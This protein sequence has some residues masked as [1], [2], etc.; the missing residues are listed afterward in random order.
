MINLRTPVVYCFWQKSVPPVRN[1]D[2]KKKRRRTKNKI[3]DKDA[4]NE[5]KK[6]SRIRSHDYQAWD[7]FDVVIILILFTSHHLFLF[8]TLSATVLEFVL[9]HV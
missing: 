5:D 1:K 7:K 3:S 6:S 8:V 2:F 9:S 4:A